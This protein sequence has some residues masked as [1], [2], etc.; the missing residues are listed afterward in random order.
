MAKTSAIRLIYHKLYMSYER[1]NAPA[2]LV[3]TVTDSTEFNPGDILEK[4]T[5]DDLCASTK[6]KVSISSHKD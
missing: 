5:V 1:G 3:D 6:W 2:W 4:P